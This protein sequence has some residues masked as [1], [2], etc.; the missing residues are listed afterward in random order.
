MGGCGK[1]KKGGGGGAGGYVEKLGK[2]KIYFCNET[3]CVK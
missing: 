3:V 2:E 1:G